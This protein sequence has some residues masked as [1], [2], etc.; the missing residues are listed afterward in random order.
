MLGMGMASMTVVEMVSDSC[1]SFRPPPRKVTAS[2]NMNA[3]VTLKNGPMG[4]RS[5]PRWMRKKMSASTAHAATKPAQIISVSPTALL[6][7]A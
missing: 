6:K 5:A 2:T 7:S 4:M 3:L 1:S